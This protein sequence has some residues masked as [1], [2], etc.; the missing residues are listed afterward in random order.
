MNVRTKFELR[1]FTRSWYNRGTQKIWAVTGYA[2]AP[3]SPLVRAASRIS[4]LCDPDPPTS[5]T[6]GQTDRQH[7]IARPHFAL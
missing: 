3:F 7:A 6:D 1:S 2:H 4:N 5:Q